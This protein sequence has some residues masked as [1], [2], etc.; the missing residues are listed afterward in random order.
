MRYQGRITRWKDEQGYGFIVPNMGGDEVF[1]H[2]KAFQPRQ[3]RPVGDEIVTYDLAFDAKGRPRA[4]AVAV[5]SGAGRR[6]VGGN[7]GPSRFPL[8]VAGL[9]LA[10]VGASTATG[11][12]PPVVL[13]GYAVISLIAFAAYALDKSAAQDGH[14]RTPENTLHL[15]ALFGGWPGALVAQNRLRHKSSKTS[16]L[17]V[18]WMTASLNCALLGLYLTPSGGRAL[19]AAL[20]LA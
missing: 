10:F 11:K 19:R 6:P 18:F 15:L 13:G 1:L 16:F 20:G 17:V 12:L 2:I 3:A 14:W 5:V 7:D 9:F 8:W 4:A